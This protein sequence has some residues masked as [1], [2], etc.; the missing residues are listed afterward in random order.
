MAASGKADITGMS[1]KL[2]TPGADAG[3]NPSHITMNNALTGQISALYRD[4]TSVAD[5]L[6]HN[7]MINALNDYRAAKYPAV[8]AQL[9]HEATG[10]LSGDMADRVLTGLQSVFK[11]LLYGSFIFVMPLILLAGGM[12]KYRGWITICLS[13][14]LW[15]P[16]FEM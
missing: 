12:S 3:Y 1:I 4:E 7:M 16:L 15:P 11:N 14:Q 9:Q 6:K 5:I 13:L 8:K 10:F 2:R